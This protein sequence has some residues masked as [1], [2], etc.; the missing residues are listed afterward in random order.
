[1]TFTQARSLLWGM[2]HIEALGYRED[3]VHYVCLPLFHVNGLHGSTLNA[4][5]RGASAAPGRP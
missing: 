5:V 2:S 1:M 3:D 4:L